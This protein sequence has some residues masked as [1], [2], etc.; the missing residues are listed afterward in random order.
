MLRSS[1][2]MGS[3]GI[4]GLAIGIGVNVCLGDLDAKLMAEAVIDEAIRNVVATGADPDRICLLDNF[5]WGNPRRPSTLGKLVDAV[6]GCCDAAHRH[7]A[8]F[9]SGKDS[10]NNEYLGS[11]GQR[12]SV[13]PTLV[14]TAFG[15]I[16]DASRRLTSDLKAAGNTLIVIGETRDEL[17]GSRL[18]AVLG[19]DAD[20]QLPTVDFAAPARYRAFHVASAEGLFVSAHDCSDGGLAAALAEMA[21]AGRLGVEH[22]FSGVHTDETVAWFSESLSRIVVEVEPDRV[23]EV[24]ARFGGSGG[25]RR[26]RDAADQSTRG[27]SRTRW[28]RHGRDTYERATRPYSHGT[29]HQPRP[30]RR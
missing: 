25:G 19:L 13:P 8:P 23:D 28:C 3:A 6:E 16:P 20:G 27:R 2:R 10:L 26:H 21:I 12:H 17:R 7:R 4:A 11:D 24:L 14:I 9:V 29:R 18:D 30:R 15:V 1:F 5:S 22:D